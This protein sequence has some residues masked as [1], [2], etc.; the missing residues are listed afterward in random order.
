LAFL[1]RWSHPLTVLGKSLERQGITGSISFQDELLVVEWKSFGLSK[2]SI[3]IV[4]FVFKMI[5]WPKY[6]SN[7]TKLETSLHS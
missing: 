2:L 6:L 7:S 4:P 1:S 3:D 5:D